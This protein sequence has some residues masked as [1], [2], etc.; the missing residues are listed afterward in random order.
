MDF[1]TLLGLA[2]SFVLVGEAV[3]QGGDLSIFVNGPALLIVLGGTLGATLTNYP[4]NV[5]LKTGA[6]IRKTLI[7]RVPATPEVVAQFMDFAYQ[8][9]REGILA[10]EK[11]IPQIDDPFLKKGL[12]LT[13]DGL[14]PDSIKMVLET[15]IDNT[16]AR[17]STSVDLLNS[18]AS[19][20]PAMGMIGTVI[21]LVQMLRTMSDP[22]NIGPSMAVALITTFYGAILSNLIF[23]PLCGK[24]KHNSSEEIRV[25]EMKL[26]G[27]LCLAKGE[28]PRILREVLEGFQSQK[29]R[30]RNKAIRQQDGEIV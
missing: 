6:I 13:V 18:M 3:A 25:M 4:L 7:N 15:E 16:H 5:L 20:A 28:N 2:V 9:R 21:G 10:L 12:L 8:A 27:L 17:H 23:L 1:A 29:E 14:E 24:L 26:A 30:Q 19:Y 11:F 22:S